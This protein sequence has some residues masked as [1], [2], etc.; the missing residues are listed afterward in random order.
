MEELNNKIIELNKKI[1][2]LENRVKSLENINKKNKIK[3]IIYY[4]FLG[5]GSIAVIIAAY[6]I[7]KNT[8]GEIMNYFN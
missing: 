1:D 2:E 8:Y 6:F 3:K 4:S 5:V 7:F